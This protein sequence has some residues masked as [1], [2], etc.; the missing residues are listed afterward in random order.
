VWGKQRPIEVWEKSHK[1]Q[2][3]KLKIGKIKIRLCT[4]DTLSP[5]KNR[6]KNMEILN[7]EGAAALRAV[8]MA[9]YPTLDSLESVV[10]LAVSQ[11][12]M[13]PN[14]VVTMLF[15]YHN[16]MLKVMGTEHVDQVNQ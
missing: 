13:T 6:K 11:V 5:S 4:A 10:H 1:Q 12:P 14:E 8:P 3:D 7:K 16:T 2:T 15:T 9:L